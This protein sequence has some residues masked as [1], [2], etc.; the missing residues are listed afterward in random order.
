MKPEPR[1]MRLACPPGFCGKRCCWPPGFCCSKKRRRNSSNGEFGN[2]GDGTASGSSAIASASA[3]CETDILTTAGETF[4]TSGAKLCCWI[5]ATGEVI[6][7]GTV[8]ETLEGLS[9]IGGFSAHTN[10][11]SANVAPRPKPIAAARFLFSH[12]WGLP[13]FVDSTNWSSYETGFAQRC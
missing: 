10:G 6:V 13:L 4:F 2:P 11:E 9:A 3:F 1:A 7:C 12:G 5:S 8:G